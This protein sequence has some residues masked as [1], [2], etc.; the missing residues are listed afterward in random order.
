MS[1]PNVSVI[2]PTYNR[3]KY[4]KESL[5]SVLAQ[6]YKDFEII[7]VD[8]GSKDNTRGI[9]ESYIKR[10]PGKIKYIYQENRGVAAARNK[11]LENAAGRYIALLDSDDIWFPEILSCQVNK[12]EQDP[13]IALVYSSYDVFDDIRVREKDLLK[14]YYKNYYSGNVL[15]E[16]L[17]WC[18]IWSSTVMIKREIFDDVG[19]F[20]E[21]IQIGE[22]YDFLLR[23]ARKYKVGCIRRVLARYRQH[24][25][26]LMKKDR[27]RQIPS[28]IVIV[29]NFT[30]K[31]PEALAGIS[32][33]QWKQ[34]LSR[35]YFDVAHQY[36][37]LGD[38]KNARKSLFSAIKYYPFK[39][40]YYK[41]LL[42]TLLPEKVIYKLGELLGKRLNED[43]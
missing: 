36:V 12:F 32:R 16:L 25:G 43:S 1:N 3:S 31:Y 27:K 28:E 20:D 34:R 7:V 6:T 22:D 37:Y 41:Y 18:F 24:K 35:P 23:V 30:K 14:N 39:F 38:F 26:N 8:D 4:I 11:A 17:L 5:D 29:E 40:V 13:G 19:S 9:V 33:T 2:I 10:F 42:I 21:N 15:R